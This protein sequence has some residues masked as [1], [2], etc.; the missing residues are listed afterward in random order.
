MLQ[1]HSVDL[2]CTPLDLSQNSKKTSSPVY[3][4][5]TTTFHLQL[6][7]ERNYPPGSRL[8]IPVNIHAPFYMISWCLSYRLSILPQPMIVGLARRHALANK[9]GMW[10]M[11]NASRTFQYPLTF[12]P[13]GPQPL[14][15][16]FSF[17][18]ENSCFFS[19]GPEMRRHLKLS[20]ASKAA[21]NHLSSGS[22]GKKYMSVALTCFRVFFVPHLR[23]NSSI[24]RGP[25]SC[26]PWEANTY[27][28]LKKPGFFWYTGRQVGDSEEW[29]LCRQQSMSATVQTEECV[30]F[31]YSC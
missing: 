17:Y 19:L 10:H 2:I 28:K 12:S 15:L 7:G 6:K 16:S 13:Q 29:L 11:S 26:G 23:V 8:G 14:A 3:L 31:Q 18:H 27:D 21:A 30:N 24:M 5:R 4:A 25:A 20:W 22:L 1:V 9:M